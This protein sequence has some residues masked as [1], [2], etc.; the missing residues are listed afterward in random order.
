MIAI[1]MRTTN[2]IGLTKS[3]SNESVQ[4]GAHN[5]E[6]PPVRKKSVS[7]TADTKAPPEPVRHESDDGKKSVSF[8]DKIA[9]MPAAPP[10]DTRSV[11]F[12]P[13][14]EEIPAEPTDATV[15]KT[16]KAYRNR[17]PSGVSLS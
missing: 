5:V 8:N 6:R 15:S 11:S 4:E 10:P 13:Q 1:S 12:S 17:I 14:V 9:V 3:R 7:F 2:G 16:S